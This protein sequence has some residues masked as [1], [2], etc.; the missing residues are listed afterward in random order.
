MPRFLDVSDTAA[1]RTALGATSTGSALVTAV[2]AAAARVAL[3]GPGGVDFIATVTER[4]FGGNNAVPA[5]YTASVGE[6]VPVDASFNNFTVLLPSAP[7]NGSMV[8]VKRVDSEPLRT[9][10]VTRQGSDVFETPGG[11]TSFVLRLPSQ[12]V[13]FQYHD[14][15]WRSVSNFAPLFRYAL[16]GTPA[17]ALISRMTIAP[18]DTRREIIEGLISD[19][20]ACGVWDKLDALYV[21]AAHDVQAARLNWK[22]SVVAD[23]TT[24]NAP[25]F[26]VDRGFTGDGGAAYLDTNTVP[27]QY[28]KYT[29]NDATLGV[30]VR[31]SVNL[32]V[33][34]ISSTPFAHIT[35]AASNNIVVRVNS[36]SFFN[37]NNAGDRTGLFAASRLTG[38]NTG[39]AYKDGQAAGSGA[40]SAGILPGLP[41]QFLRGNLTSY[42]TRQIAAGFWGAGLTSQEH[43]DLNTALTIY[44]T[45]VGAA[46]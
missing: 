44:L 12:T 30:Y 2:D 27:T 24:V 1:A 10:T 33:N 19:L 37:G 25:L 18:S 14:G 26:T 40:Q 15:V 35:A 7:A 20:R 31:N 17:E 22:G 42:S 28:V 21:F 46:V 41:M 23:A 29:A 8:T 38:S 3:G 5:T 16:L 11:I 43:A 13:T 39:F 36:S 45:A 4:K 6:L 32:N 9:V 34:D